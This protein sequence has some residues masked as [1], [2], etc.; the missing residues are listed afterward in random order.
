MESYGPGLVGYNMMMAELNHC[1]FHHNYWRP[2][3]D[4]SMHSN[5]TNNGLL[6][7]KAGQE[8]LFMCLQ[9]IQC[10]TFTRALSGLGVSFIQS[11]LMEEISMNVQLCIKLGGCALRIIY[12]HMLGYSISGSFNITIYNCSMYKNT[13]SVGGNLFCVRAYLLQFKHSHC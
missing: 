6:D 8:M 11:L 2:W 10:P 1:L 3:V 9:T 5:T 7:F 12:N 4:S 13:A